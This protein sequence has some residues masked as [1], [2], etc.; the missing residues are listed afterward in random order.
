[1]GKFIDKSQL[2]VD[3]TTNA[4]GILAIVGAAS[5]AYEGIAHGTPIGVWLPAFVIGL[6]TA[7]AQWLQ[8]T[9]SGQTKAIAKLL[10]LEGETNVDLGI[11][12]V[13]RVADAGSI[14]RAPVVSADLDNVGIGTGTRRTPPVD[15]LF[16]NPEPSDDPSYSAYRAAQEARSSLGVAPPEEI[17]QWKQ[18]SSK[19]DGGEVQPTEGW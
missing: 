2:N 1:M 4:T 17:Q 9:P 12:L 18:W 19:D 7:V 15:R 14:D 8:G 10:K 11:D 13:R 5:A 6:S 3:R 16:V